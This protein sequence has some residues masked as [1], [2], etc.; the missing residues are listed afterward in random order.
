M[1]FQ[2]R[3]YQLYLGGE[4]CDAASGDTFES[5]C[6]GDGQLVATVA[7]AGVADVN[8][9]VEAAKECFYDCLLYTSPSPRD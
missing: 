6:P 5:R 9:A 2:P 1:E 8:R 4:W 7:K 3:D